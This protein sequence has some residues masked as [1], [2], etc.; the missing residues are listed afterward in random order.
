MAKV[1]WRLPET[2]FASFSSQI[3]YIDSQLP[4]QVPLIL[5]WALSV[6]KSQGQTIERVKVDLGSVFEKGQGST[7]LVP[8]CLALIAHTQSAYVALSRA[9][10]LETLEVLNFKPSKC[11]IVVQPYFPVLMMR[12][13]GDGSPSSDCLDQDIV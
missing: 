11:V 9:T 12:F 1:K 13:Q 5:A 6:H 2:R 3:K 7:I 8:I 10:S 4:E